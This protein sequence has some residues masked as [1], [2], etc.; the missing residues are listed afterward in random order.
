MTG[1]SDGSSMEQVLHM[2][3]TDCT[4]ECDRFVIKNNSLDTSQP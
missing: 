4:L 1:F 2:S 3:P